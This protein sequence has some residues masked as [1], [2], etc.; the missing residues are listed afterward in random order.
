MMEI[1]WFFLNSSTPCGAC[2]TEQLPRLS[3]HLRHRL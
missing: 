2:T 3:T 1:N